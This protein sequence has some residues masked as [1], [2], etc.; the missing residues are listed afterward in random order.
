MRKF[1]CAASANLFI[2]EYLEAYPR[3][4]LGRLPITSLWTTNQLHNWWH[5]F[6]Y[7]GNLIKLAFAHPITSLDKNSTSMN[8]Q[9]P[10]YIQNDARDV[11]WLCWGKK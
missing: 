3:F 8:M 9:T 4:A 10:A 6:Q 1:F 11:G 5:G 7:Q 2:F